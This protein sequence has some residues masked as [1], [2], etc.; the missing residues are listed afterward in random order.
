MGTATTVISWVVGLALAGGVWYVVFV[1]LREPIRMWRQRKERKQ[2]A[3]MGVAMILGLCFLLAAS[4][5]VP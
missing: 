1:A 4:R 3:L 5:V 2:A